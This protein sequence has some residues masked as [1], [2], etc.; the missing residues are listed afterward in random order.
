MPK[1]T[2]D[3]SDDFHERLETIAKNSGATKEELILDGLEALLD[4]FDDMFTEIKRLM[5]EYP[6]L[7]MEEIEAKIRDKFDVDEDEEEEEHTHTTKGCCHH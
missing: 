1:I 5:L 6:N 2:I 4:H 3:I 7:S